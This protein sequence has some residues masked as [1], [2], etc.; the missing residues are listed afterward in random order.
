[1]SPRA[2]IVAEV[3]YVVFGSLALVLLG[4]AIYGA[5]FLAWRGWDLLPIVAVV[6]VSA[7]FIFAAL[8]DAPRMYD[9]VRRGRR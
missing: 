7:I 6:G 3:R 1:M 9:D 8:S 5:F 2:S 4:A